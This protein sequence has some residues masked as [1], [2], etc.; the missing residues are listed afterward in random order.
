MV[1]SVVGA[2]TVAVVSLLLASL[3][4][5]DV[6]AA[7]PLPVA[8]LGC[9]LPDAGR[10]A[11]WRAE[12]TAED[13][14]QGLDG[15]SAGLAYAA[16]VVGA[17][18]DLPGDGDHVTVPDAAALDITTDLTLDTWVKIDD[19]TFGTP[20]AHGI[21]GDRALFWKVDPTDRYGTYAFWIE[22]NDHTA[23][24]APLTFFHGDREQAG[25]HA[26]S[27][28]LEWE[29]DRWYHVAAVRSGRDVT[30][31]R[32][33]QPVGAGAMLQDAAATPGAP[34]ALGA[35]PLP[36]AIYHPIKGDLDEAEIWDRALAGDEV[37][38]IHDT[39]TGECRRPP[40][41]TIDSGP[42]GPTTLTTPTFTFSSD[43][44]AATF[45]CRID[46]AAFA[47][48]TTPHTTAALAP[49]E[50][51]FEVRAVD[52]RGTPDPTPARRAF[53]VASPP[54]PNKPLNVLLPSIAGVPGQ[55]H[56]YRCLP[57]AWN[58]RDPAIAFAFSWQRITPDKAYVG[59]VRYDEVATGETYRPVAALP[60]PQP[61]SWR[62]R[63]VVTA[64]NA[65]GST[66]AI[67]PTV[68]LDPAPPP[69]LLDEPYG[70][71]RVRGI[72]VF[73]VVQPSAGARAFGYT[74][75]ADGS[76][77]AAG[78]PSQAFGFAMAGGG[79][80]TSYDRTFFGAALRPGSDAQRT[81]YVGV[82]LDRSKP[83]TAIVY[84]DVDGARP[85]DWR[86]ELDVSLTANANGTAYAPMIKTIWNPQDTYTPYV[87]SEQRGQGRFGVQF[88]IPSSW[89]S[90]GVPDEGL[91]LV[92]RVAFKKGFIL[93]PHQCATGCLSDDSFRLE[94][95]QLGPTMPRVRIMS[96]DLRESTDRWDTDP[97]EVLRRATQL[98][99]GGERMQ[100][101]RSGAT[102]PIDDIVAR[103]IDS[104][105]CAP[106]K[107]VARG[108]RS[109][110]ADGIDVLLND[111]QNRHKVLDSSYDVLMGIHDYRID[112]NGQIE[113][114]WTQASLTAWPGYHHPTFTANQGSADPADRDVTGRNAFR[115]DSAERPLTAAAHEL[116][117]VLGLEHA[118]WQCPVGVGQ[119][120]NL[121][122]PD[123][124]QPGEY[125]PADDR[126]RLQGVAFDATAPGPLGQI[127]PHVDTD[128]P[129]TP[130]ALPNPRFDLMSYC[131]P[132]DRAW[133]SARNWNHTYK[134]MQDYG[135]RISRATARGAAPD[136]AGFAVGVIGP[137]GG[138]IERIVPADAD[139]RV[140][141]PV[142]A[143]TVRLRALDATG[144]VLQDAGVQVQTSTEQPAGHGG[145]F[146]GPVPAAAAAVELVRDDAVLQRITRSQ[147]PTV[148]LGAPAR[149]AHVR[150]GAKSSLVVRWTAKDPD[151]DRLTA[152]IDYSAD[153]GHS[154]KTVYQG[155]SSGRAQIAAHDLPGSDNA[156]IRV[157]V[158]DGF[159]EPRAVSAPFRSD[160]TAP[161]VRILRPLPVDTLQA[162]VRTQLAG[163][164]LDDRLRAVA[165]RD[166]TWYAGRTPLGHGETLNT[167][168]PAGRYALALVARDGGGRA[169]RASVKVRVERAPLRLLKLAY[170]GRVAG[171]ARRLTVQIAAS[172][173]ATLRAAG[174]V[175]R[176]GPVARTVV[177]ALPRAKKGA[178]LRIACRVV[179]G[180]GRSVGGT[181]VAQRA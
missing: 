15:S 2:A 45:E 87:T 137:R 43:D 100:I 16:G 49:G 139:S 44:P 63:C 21:G 77:V 121:T 98:Y 66:S 90:A 75:R 150:A 103:T 180:D 142:P 171:H 94:G 165:G 19:T 92:A 120:G 65:A 18:F 140:P 57:G 27:D 159:N 119:P 132:E 108:L 12:G 153:G 70:N 162:G 147:P 134:V 79:T 123:A 31:Y 50:H 117:H 64:F 122:G 41:T 91:D 58:G 6:G 145:T 83:A 47:A 114:G 161:A 173:P 53:T 110:R 4:A 76:V 25:A 61:P 179:T 175:Y 52:D 23:A 112:P 116:G 124:D 113:P 5:D 28:G 30:F 33:G 78:D 67:S 29:R 107:D 104:E 152:T 143:A 160:G 72:D 93:K 148:T 109:C 163:S 138:R 168:L 170:V 111:Y 22:A 85:A 40:E 38:A 35:A 151:G 178:L 146:T 54:V 102:L 172:E 157:G 11:L 99:P 74:V 129:V 174:R 97:H 176:V 13:T 156:R 55:A 7:P 8:P 26:Y 88:K 136:G 60:T 56:A 125:W 9:V 36:D 80:P 42:A 130:P 68:V 17:A 71:F 105:Q 51:T 96:I 82:P 115:D 169:G 131:A 155:P 73:Q 144:D 89:L 167:T 95:L 69:Q 149:G 86:Q 14:V 37:K 81:N 177:L 62:F 101:F 84:V 128:V 46:G 166:L 1:V 48:C 24:N 127:D 3:M 34:L 20:D 135:R 32:D 158:N 118:G 181:I 164:A 106:W 133:L 126:G 10:V 59:G 154:W 39:T 141:V